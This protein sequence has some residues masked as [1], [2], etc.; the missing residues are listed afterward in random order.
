MKKSEASKRRRT[1]SRL[2]D[3]DDA[4]LVTVRGGF[5][6][7]IMDAITGRDAGIKGDVISEPAGPDNTT[8]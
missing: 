6:S 7:I 4:R 2:E 3:V 5:I 8:H 1:P